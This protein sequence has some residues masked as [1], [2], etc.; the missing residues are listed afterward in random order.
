[1]LALRVLVALGE[2]EVNDVDVVLRVVAAANQEV[3]G[4]DVAM[5]DSLLVHLLNAVDLHTRVD[6]NTQIRIRSVKAALPNPKA[7][8]EWDDLPSA[9]RC[10]A[11]S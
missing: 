6:D 5:D 1:M 3:V 11:Q 4:L 2:A 8:P 7:S 9:R 10:G